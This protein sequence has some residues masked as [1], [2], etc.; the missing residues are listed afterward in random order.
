MYCKSTYVKQRNL[1]HCYTVI[2]VNEHNIA[3]M[4]YLSLFKLQNHKFIRHSY[5]YCSNSQ[6]EQNYHLGFEPAVLPCLSAATPT[7]RLSGSHTS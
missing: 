3:A 1:L 5:E 2:K 4:A 6:T 7:A